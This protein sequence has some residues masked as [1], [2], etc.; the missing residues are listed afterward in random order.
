MADD[1][2]PTDLAHRYNLLE[3]WEGKDGILSAYEQLIDKDLKNETDQAL[4]SAITAKINTLYV[5][6]ADE[7]T[8]RPDFKELELEFSS[9]IHLINDPKQFELEENRG[10]LFKLLQLMAKIMAVLKITKG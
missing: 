7:L 3:R 9:F 6:I 2:P 5:A 10:K 4:L 8:D 1:L